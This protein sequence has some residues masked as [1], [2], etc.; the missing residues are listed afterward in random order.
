[1]G[2]PQAIHS[3][4]GRL[5]AFSTPKW[6]MLAILDGEASTISTSRWNSSG[7]AGIKFIPR[8]AWNSIKQSYSPSTNQIHI[9][10]STPWKSCECATSY[11][12]SVWGRGTRMGKASL[13][14]PEMHRIGRGT[15]STGTKFT[16]GCAI[17]WAT[18]ASTQIRRS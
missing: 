8:V 4:M 7:S 18:Y 13:R 15:L 11:R 10:L 17:G 6:V 12:N 1:M 5:S 2:P 16:S 3:R 9:A 14:L